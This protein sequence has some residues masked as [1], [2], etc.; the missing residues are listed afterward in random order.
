MTESQPG[1]ANRD[2]HPCPPWCEVDHDT[3]GTSGIRASHHGTEPPVI[4]FRDGYVIASAYQD[5]FS[6]TPPQIWIGSLG[7]PPT[8]IDPAQA[9]VLAALAEMLAGADADQ[10]RELAEQI[11]KAAVDITGETGEKP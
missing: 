6:D 11:R 8:L 3:T 2:G 10:H 4:S 7:G 9:G 5:G 1:R